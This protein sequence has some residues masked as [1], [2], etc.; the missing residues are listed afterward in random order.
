MKRFSLNK[1]WLLSGL[2]FFCLNVEWADAELGAESKKLATEDAP[3]VGEE[4]MEFN[5]GYSFNRSTKQWGTNWETT[6]REELTEHWIEPTLTYGLTKDF[7]VWLS[8]G[9]ANLEDLESDPSHGGGVTDLD[10]GLKWGLIQDD[11]KALYLSWLNGFTAPVGRYETENH[12]GPGGRFW[13]YNSA[14]VLTKGLWERWV[15]DFETFGSLAFGEHREN[16]RGTIGIN[17]ALGYALF[18]SVQPEIELNYEHGFMRKDHDADV[19]AIT[20]GLICPI[21]KWS[22][23]VGLGAQQGIAGRC[24]DKKNERVVDDHL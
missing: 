11:S 12:L 1:C 9:Y 20:A 15:W 19:L 4:V 22:L 21:E 23:I 24:E 3:L 14:V 13:R 16:E 2:L 6:H 5:L 18:E 8:A 10:F 7:D 17:T